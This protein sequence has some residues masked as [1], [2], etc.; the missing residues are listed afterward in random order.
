MNGCRAIA[1]TLMIAPLVLLVGLFALSWRAGLAGSGFVLAAAVAYFGAG[2][3]V[4][5]SR[6]WCPACNLKKLK[7]I[8]WFTANP[9]PN[10]SF[11]RCETVEQNSCEL[12][13]NQDWSS[14]VNPD[15]R[16]LRGGKP[17]QGGPEEKSEGVMRIRF[18]RRRT[19]RG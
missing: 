9:P 12:M 13:V 4:A 19:R 16:T 15:S 14:G 2:Y 18:G 8:N 17:T 7:C 3:L 11:Y 5:R 10:W 6:R 1:W